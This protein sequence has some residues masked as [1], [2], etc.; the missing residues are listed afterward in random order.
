MTDTT[1]TVPVAKF[2]KVDETNFPTYEEAKACFDALSKKHAKDVKEER[3][4]FRIR[5]RPNGTFDVTQHV[6]L[7]AKKDE[8]AA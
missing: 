2:Q 6:A 3:A 5:L 1:K 4:K 8:K 7:P